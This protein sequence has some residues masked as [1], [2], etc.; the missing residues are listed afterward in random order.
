[1]FHHF[2]VSKGKKKNTSA[3]LPFWERREGGAKEG[4]GGARGAGLRPIERKRQKS[5]HSS[6][7]IS[8]MPTPAAARCCPSADAD[9]ADASSS[10][11]PWPSSRTNSSALWWSCSAC[12]SSSS[13]WRPE[14]NNNNN[15]GNNNNNKTDYSIGCTAEKSFACF[16][17]HRMACSFP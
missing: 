15:N 5:F 6:H 11:S 10:F 7:S 8:F 3:A 12:C 9:A 4:A 1:M 14:R 2:P 17:C 16:C 13:R